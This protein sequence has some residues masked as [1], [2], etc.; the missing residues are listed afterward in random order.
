AAIS[1]GEVHITNLEED[2]LQGDRIILDIL[3]KAGAEVIWQSDGVMVRGNSLHGVDVDMHSFPD[4]VPTVAVLGL[5]CAGSTR[6]GN[7]AH[8]RFK[9][10]DRLQ[11][12]MENISRLQGKAFTEGDN[13][14]IEPQ[15]LKGASLPTYNDHRIA[16]SFALAGLRVPGVIIEHPGCANKSYPDFWEHFDLLHN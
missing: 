14:I 16:M 13:L 9:E 7:V 11:A 10:S 8:L 6:L 12:I 5:F 1:G 4:L 3:E 2:S 15:R